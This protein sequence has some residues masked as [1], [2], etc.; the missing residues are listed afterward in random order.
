VHQVHRYLSAAFAD[1]GEIELRM[2]HGDGQADH[3]LVTPGSDRIAG[4]LDF[5]DAVLGDP[6]WD[7]AILTLGVPEMVS[8]VR[9]GY[10][11]DEATERRTQELLVAYQLIRRLGSASW[12]RE[13]GQPHE[14]DLRAALGILALQG[15]EV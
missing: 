8:E 3:Y 9:L 7:L 4:I 12:M 10:Q 1:M 11:P 13:H 5:G 6:V 14:P 2:L 15:W